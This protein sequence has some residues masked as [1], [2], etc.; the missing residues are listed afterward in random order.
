MVLQRRLG[1]PRPAAPGPWDLAL[2]GA[3]TFRLSRLIAKATITRPLRAPFTHVD[4]AGA[5]AE[6]N[7]TPREEPGRVTAGELISCPF[8]LSVWI[9]TTFTGARAIWPSGGR[10]SH[11]Q[12]PCRL[13][14]S[15][16]T[17]S[18]TCADPA[19]P[20]SLRKAGRPI[21]PRDSPLGLRSTEGYAYPS[22]GIRA[23]DAASAYTRPAR[24]SFVRTRESHNIG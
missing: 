20:E 3:A 6:L 10:R 19:P 13:L 5:P 11:P 18:V 24:L 14:R 22:R 23:R 16:R 2:T 21:R 15:D 4:G 7:E 8:C 17:P 1:R 9:V 12:Q